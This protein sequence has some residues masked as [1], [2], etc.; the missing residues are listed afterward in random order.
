V[1]NEKLTGSF[2]RDA[3]FEEIIPIID[4]T[5]ICVEASDIASAQLREN[6][7]DAWQLFSVFTEAITV[8]G[9]VWRITSDPDV[10]LWL[11]GNGFEPQQPLTILSEGIGIHVYI[12]I[13]LMFHCSCSE[14]YA[15]GIPI[16]Y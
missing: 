11:D 16:F 8:S 15:V 2:P 5:S 7:N 9:A 3:D 13:I 12:I 1:I 4:F 6:G 14:R 10:E